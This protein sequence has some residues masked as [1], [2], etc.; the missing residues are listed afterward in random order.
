MACFITSEGIET[1]KNVHTIA[2]SHAMST[3][4]T[5]LDDNPISD[6]SVLKLK[7]YNYTKQSDCVDKRF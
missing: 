7:I 5:Q 3:Q 2:P 1:R 6:R 4:M